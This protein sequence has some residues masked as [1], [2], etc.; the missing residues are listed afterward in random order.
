[1]ST[2]E[3]KYSLHSLIDNISD[4]KT[5]NAIYTLLSKTFD[6]SADNEKAKIASV[7]K[8]ISQIAKGQTVNHKEVK[9]IYQKWL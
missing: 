6:V 2:V 4:S 3:L 9:K 7:K 1:M 8:G 5:L